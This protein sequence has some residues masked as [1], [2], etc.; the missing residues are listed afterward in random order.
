[1]LRIPPLNQH[2]ENNAPRA[3]V[4]LQAVARLAA[5]LTAPPAVEARIPR[6][7]LE[8]QLA[9]SSHPGRLQSFRRLRSLWQLQF[10]LREELHSAVM[11]NQ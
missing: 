1:M 4:K 5:E 2:V 6:K 9:V 7:S 11:R 3:T 10:L 8:N